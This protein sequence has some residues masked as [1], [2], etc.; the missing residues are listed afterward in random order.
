MSAMYEE[1]AAAPA[2][3][4]E[5]SRGWFHTAQQLR[6]TYL[7][8]QHLALLGRGTS[9]NACTF[10]AYLYGLRTGRHAIE[11]RPWLVT[12]DV[13]NA[14][15]SDTAAL[16][17]SYS[18]RST[19]IAAAA[20][21][22]KERGANVVGVTNTDDADC[23]LGKASHGLFTL[24]VGEERAVPAT[25]SY[26]AQLFA[27]AA[28]CGFE[29]EAP[30]M[31]A[32]RCMDALLKSTVAQDLAE[33]LRD[34]RSV[35]WIARGPALAA[36]LD[37]ALKLQETAATPSAGWSAAEYL[38]GPIGATEA[39]DRVVLLAD[40]DTPADSMSATASALLGRG[41]PFVRVGAGG[42]TTP[43]SLELPDERWARTVVL[44]MLSQL[45]AVHLAQA[46]GLDPDAPRGLRKVTL[47]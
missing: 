41:V 35:A 14:N 28:L 20:A 11:F 1:I 5:R 33:F 23:L 30:A 38:H 8:R 34:A 7:N 46:R 36:A 27:S 43:L 17:Y 6:D 18:G 31:D 45:V 25:K 32:A 19:D 42:L 26:C 21:W 39:Q 2:L 37:A 22:L 15:Y 24:G 9:G 47:T 12:Q 29:I 13:P 4:R 40:A 44:S 3:L 16:V 10:A